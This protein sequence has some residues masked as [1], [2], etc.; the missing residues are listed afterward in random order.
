[1][2]N[3]QSYAQRE[4]GIL[5]KFCTD[6]DNRPIIEP[7]IPEILALCEKFGNSGQSGGSAPYTATALSQAIKKLCLQEPIMPMTGIDDEW[8]DVSRYGDGSNA[9]DEILYQNRRCG[10]LFKNRNG[11]CW[12]LDAIVWKGDT[13]GESGND[14]DTFTGNVEGF[15]SRQYV[16]SFPFTPKTFYIEVTREQLPDDWTEEP[17]IEGKEWYD[18]AEYERTGIKN[19]HKNNYRY[20]IKDRSQLDRVFKYYDRYDK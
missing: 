12:Y 4:L 15:L 9:S 19:W 1:M 14:W 20:I 16:K 11:R 10:G 7:F 18:T 6:P 3:T 2:T 5:V 8:V 13:E 17:F